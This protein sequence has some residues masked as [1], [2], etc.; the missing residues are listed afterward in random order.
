MIIYTKIIS[1]FEKQQI[2]EMFNQLL[3]TNSF[4]THLQLLY[5]NHKHFTTV[6]IDKNLC[7]IA[8]LY[9]IAQIAL[10][11]EYTI[12]VEGTI[13]TNNHISNV[14]FNTKTKTPLFVKD[15][16]IR[17]SFDHIHFMHILMGPPIIETAPVDYYY[18]NELFLDSICDKPVPFNVISPIFT[19]SADIPIPIPRTRS[20][21]IKIVMPGGKYI[22]RCKRKTNGKRKSRKYTKR[23]SVY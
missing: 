20:K 22:K 14:L 7:S 10:S 13:H 1:E 12:F 17:V 8:Q 4:Y 18:S 5:N 3:Y 9:N 16:Y 2:H 19:M 23:K 21:A 11:I 6:G 15:T